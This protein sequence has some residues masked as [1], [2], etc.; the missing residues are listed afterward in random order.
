MRSFRGKSET[1]N[2]T[3]EIKISFPLN[4]IIIVVEKNR[5]KYYAS[6]KRKRKEKEKEKRET[7][8]RAGD[9]GDKQKAA[10]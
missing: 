10:E 9:K 5:G 8:G 1:A 3:G 6:K 2:Q 7:D 4:E